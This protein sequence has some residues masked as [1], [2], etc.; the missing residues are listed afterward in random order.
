M[1]KKRRYR[2]L[3]PLN[4]GGRILPAGF[5][6]LLDGADVGVLLSKKIVEEIKD[7]SKSKE[8]EKNGNSSGK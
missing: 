3:K 5:E 6:G 2:V 1:S 7:S 8:G 4:L